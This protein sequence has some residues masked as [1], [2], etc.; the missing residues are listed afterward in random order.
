MTDDIQAAIEAFED[1]PVLYDEQHVAGR[2]DALDRLEFHVI[3]RIDGLLQG[4]APAPQLRALRLRAERVRRRLEAIDDALARRVRDEI[5]AGAGSSA[6]RSVLGAPC[7]SESERQQDSARYDGLDSFVNRVLHTG[8]APEP[9]LA[10][11]P[12]MVAFQ[13]TPARVV[14]ALV[15]AAR[16]TDADAFFDLGSGLG[17]VPILVN[18]L[19]GATATGVEVEPAW[20]PYARRCAAELNLRRVEFIHADAR[21]ADY[22]TGTVFFMYTPFTGRMLLDVLERLRGEARRRSIRVFTYGPCTSEIARQRWLRCEGES[23]AGYAALGAFAS[24]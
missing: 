22:S 20:C 21:D 9:E 24:R 17:R 11:Q 2:A 4:G 23:S 7:C 19:S 3:D 18:L 1:D 15:E 6:L 14:L 16:L 13:P 8:P 5:R 10:L 12:E